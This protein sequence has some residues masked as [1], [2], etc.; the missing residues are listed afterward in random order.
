MTD[1]TTEELAVEG[2]VKEYL[3][4][5]LNNDDLE[6]LKALVRSNQS[7]LQNTIL[8][9]IELLTEKAK[10]E[11]S[12]CLDWLMQE[13]ARIRGWKKS[14][15]EVTLEKGGRSQIS[16]GIEIMRAEVKEEYNEIP[17][18]INEVLTSENFARTGAAMLI[19]RHERSEEGGKG[20]T[21]YQYFSTDPGDMRAGVK[22]R[23]CVPDKMMNKIRSVADEFM[24]QRARLID[25]G[26][27]TIIDFAEA[28][29]RKAKSYIVSSGNLYDPGH[30]YNPAYEFYTTRG[31]LARVHHL[32]DHLSSTLSSKRGSPEDKHHGVEGIGG[33]GMVPRDIPFQAVVQAGAK[34]S[35]D[36]CFGI[37]IQ[38]GPDGRPV[39]YRRHNPVNTWALRYLNC[40]VDN[41]LSG[42]HL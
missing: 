13:N 32:T 34:M 24:L 4:F 25:H 15:V 5:D 2:A 7:N 26:L 16:D 1:P 8:E 12:K 29:P 17:A 3:S 42:R 38:L 37:D 20:D 40:L 22:A 41:L 11:P 23:L 6:I 27:K 31:R 10:R 39:V 9:G 28:E 14:S 36:P 19:D 18:F 35:L 33:E 21:R 30:Y